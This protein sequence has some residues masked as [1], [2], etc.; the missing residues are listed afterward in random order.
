MLPQSKL[1]QEGDVVAGPFGAGQAAMQGL[2]RWR[3]EYSSGDQRH[4]FNLHRVS[5]LCFP[6]LLQQRMTLVFESVGVSDAQHHRLTCTFSCVHSANVCSMFPSC[7][8][9]IR[10]QAAHTPSLQGFYSNVLIEHSPLQHEIEAG[11]QVFPTYSQSWL[12]RSKGVGRGRT[13]LWR[14]PHKVHCPNEFAVTGCERRLPPQ[15]DLVAAMHRH[16]VLGYPHVGAHRRGKAAGGLRVCTRRQPYASGNHQ[17]LG[18]PC[19][20]IRL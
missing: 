2:Q 3:Q 19:A 1:G 6:L 20:H 4:M 16:R 14:V 12:H 17:L 7:L 11:R 9:E 10:E 15:H 18:G 5:S 8:A 13:H